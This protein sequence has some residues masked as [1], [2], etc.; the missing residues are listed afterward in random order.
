MNNIQHNKGIDFQALVEK[1]KQL[2]PA[3]K[4]KLNDV[5]WNENIEI[6]VEHQKLVVKRI[7]NSVKSPERMLDWDE[8]LKTLKS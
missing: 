6:P 3:E 8:A 7:A 2:S 1:V 5:L 4:L